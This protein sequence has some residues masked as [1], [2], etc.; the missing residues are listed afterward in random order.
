[1]SAPRKTSKHIRAELFIRVLKGVPAKQRDESRG[2]DE[3]SHDIVTEIFSKGNCGNFAIMFHMLFPESEL[4]YACDVMS[5]EQLVT[6]VICKL[7][8]RW[9]DISGDI[10]GERTLEAVERAIPEELMNW[11][12]RHNIFDNYSF[13]ARGP[14]R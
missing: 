11:E 8:G 4:W 12:S 9:Y 6:H 2:D 14:L 5:P 3:S 10:S 13:K 7:D 1:M